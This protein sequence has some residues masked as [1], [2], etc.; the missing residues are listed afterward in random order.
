MV[1]LIGV[2]L[3]LIIWLIAWIVCLGISWLVWFTGCVCLLFVV[4]GV[5]YCLDIYFAGFLLLLCCVVSWILVVLW[6][7][8]FGVL[9]LLC[10]GTCCLLLVV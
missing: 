10:N 6:F 9:C 8:L 7:C 2:C 5:L 1:G 4:C 3:R